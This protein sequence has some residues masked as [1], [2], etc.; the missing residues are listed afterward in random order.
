MIK[1][2]KEAFEEF[3]GM[4]DCVIFDCPPSLSTLAQ[5]ALKLSDIIISPINVDR[6]SMWSLRSFWMQGLDQILDL[7]NHQHRYALLTMVHTGRGGNV[8]KQ[9][10]RDDLHAF[11]GQ[12]RFS[13][14]IPYTVEAL[15]YV[16]RAD[17]DSYRKFRS[18]Y[19]RL[20]EPIRRLG[21]STMN[22]MNSIE[23]E[24]SREQ[25]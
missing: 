5:S 13:E 4:F 22:I 1:F 20:R 9:A 3:S 7:K 21:E 10:V 18:K 6:V 17:V 2:F 8:E 11:A 24:R 15:R 12:R 25:K 19:G 14:E 23:K 16:R